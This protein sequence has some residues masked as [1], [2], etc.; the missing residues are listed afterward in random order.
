MNEYLIY[1]TQLLCIAWGLEIIY[2]TFI[3]QCESLT[4][5]GVFI[6]NEHQEIRLTTYRC[7]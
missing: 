4:H 5:V 3:D 6:G 1:G 2:I 7:A